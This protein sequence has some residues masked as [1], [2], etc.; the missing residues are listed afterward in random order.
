MKKILVITPYC[1][2]P[3]HKSGG[4]HALLNIINENKKF[5]NRIDLIYYDEKDIDG[6]NELRKYVD[7]IEYRDLRRS[8]RFTRL[9]S[10]IKG[11]PYGIYQY[12]EEK[13]QGIEGYDKVILDQPLSMKLVKKIKAKEKILIAYD[14]MN[15]YFKRKSSIDNSNFIEKAYSNIQ[16]KYYEMIQK[17]FFCE[18]NKIYYVSANDALYEKK[19]NHINDDKIDFINLGVD[20]SKYDSSKYECNLSAD[21]K[22]IIFTGIMS[23]AP[24]KDAAIFFAN[25]IMPEIIKRNRNTKF[26][27]VGKNP[28]R[29]VLNLQNEY[30]EVTGFVDDIVEYISNAN[31]YVS[32]LR[33]GTGMKNKVL[34]AM[35]CS[36]AIIASTI[37]VEGINELINGENIY[38]PNSDDE[39]VGYV[40]KLLY[41]EELNCKFGSECRSVILKKYNWEKAYIK[42]FN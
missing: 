34:E 39:W 37:S 17:K 29:E 23:Y 25:K 8:S 32:P 33:F 30:V 27:I 15:L 20:Y 18:F 35:S 24:N 4:I 42:I 14:S 16:S 11:I 40:E 19:L 5:G 3:L 7:N 6:E 9:I 41:D 36:K 38:I 21:K 12:N 2:F 1:P 31:I 13:L 10:I 26:I 22:V 28:D